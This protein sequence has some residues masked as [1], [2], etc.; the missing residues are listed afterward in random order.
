MHRS[1]Q[2]VSVFNVFT[3]FPN[4]KTEFFKVVVY[5]SKILEYMYIYLLAK[6]QKKEAVM[7]FSTKKIITLFAVL[8][9]I[10]ISSIA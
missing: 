4:F 2:E 10:L 7:K 3:K 8:T 6:R 9:L 1:Q 5:F